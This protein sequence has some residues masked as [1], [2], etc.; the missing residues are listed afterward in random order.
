VLILP[1][2]MAMVVALLQLALWALAAHALSLA[3]AEAGAAARSGQTAVAPAIVRS[4]VGKIA[5]GAVGSLTV[6]V[7]ALPDNFVS[8]SATGTVPT[9]LPGLSLHVSATSVGPVQTFRA[10]G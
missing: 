6:T 9:V 10:S 1:A 2:L 5:A 7:S 3:V 4:D 8:V